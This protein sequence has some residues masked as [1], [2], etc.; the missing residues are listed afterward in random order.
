MKRKILLALPGLFGLLAP[1]LSS[2][3]YSTNP[4]TAE[5]CPAVL[6]CEN[7][8]IPMAN[9]NEWFKNDDDN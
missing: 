1:A 5:G 8:E 3:A 2:C 7:G 9:G 6:T 4:T